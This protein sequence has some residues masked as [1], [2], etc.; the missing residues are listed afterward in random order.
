MGIPVLTAIT[1]RAMRRRESIPVERR[2]ES[3]SS[4]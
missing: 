4:K 2:K 3:W 1:I